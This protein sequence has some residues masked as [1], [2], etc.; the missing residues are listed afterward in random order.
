MQSADVAKVLANILGGIP[1]VRVH[2]Y[3]ADTTRVPAI[4]IG[5]PDVSWVD[6]DA[7]PCWATWTYPLTLVV[8]RSNDRDAQ[9][10]LSRLL[11]DTATAL[12]K[13]DP[14]ELTTVEPLNA[15]PATVTVAGQ[16]LPGYT[17]TV[18]VRA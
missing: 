15:T 14:D 2:S 12:A 16:E 17:L 8:A 4:V 13:A 10:D 1:K 6:E 7:G 5:L 11:D 3:V 18:R 9:A